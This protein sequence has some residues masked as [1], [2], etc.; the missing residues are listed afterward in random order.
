MSTL[1]VG[2][3]SVNPKEGK[4][5]GVI[6]VTERIAIKLKKPPRNS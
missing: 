2:I 5:D 1:P 3:I 4:A 6:N